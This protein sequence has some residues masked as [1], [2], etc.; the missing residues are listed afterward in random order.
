LVRVIAAISS[1]DADVS[2]SDAACCEPLP[3]AADPEVIDGR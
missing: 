1:I 2:S 3:V